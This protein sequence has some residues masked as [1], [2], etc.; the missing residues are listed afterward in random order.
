MPVGD[1]VH[2]QNSKELQARLLAIKRSSEGFSE[3]GLYSVMAAV[4]THV[5]A[6]HK[7][8]DVRVLTPL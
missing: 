1:P 6:R 3:D 4:K 2:P 7:T 5:S 8:S